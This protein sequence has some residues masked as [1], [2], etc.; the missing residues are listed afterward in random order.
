MERGF[1]RA[2]R[3]DFSQ[4]TVCE[5]RSLVRSRQKYDSDVNNAHWTHIGLTR[6]RKNVLENR[7]FVQEPP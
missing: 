3:L 6:A 4:L 1:P 2:V 5:Q 7:L